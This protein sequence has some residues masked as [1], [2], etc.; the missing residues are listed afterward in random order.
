MP[1]IGRPKARG[2]G[3]P[4]G[5]PVWIGPGRLWYDPGPFHD[6]GPFRGQTVFGVRPDAV[7]CGWPQAGPGTADDRERSPDAEREGA[8]GRGPVGMRHLRAR[9]LRPPS[10]D[11][12]HRPARGDG[13]GG[14]P[15]DRHHAGGQQFRLL[16]HPGV[17]HREGW[18]SHGDAAPADSAALVSVAGTR[19]R[20]RNVVAGGDP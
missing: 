13:V 7:R 20:Y 8:L 10:D 3:L 19:F 18:L 1:S 14:Q 6:P 5:E 11:R 2:V 4:G 15:G 12:P 17:P 16:W 9:R